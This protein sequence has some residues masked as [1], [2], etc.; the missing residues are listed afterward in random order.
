MSHRPL[1]TRPRLRHWLRQRAADR[2]RPPLRGE[3]PLQRGEARGPAGAEQQAP[4]SRASRRTRAR[5]TRG[6]ETGSARLPAPTLSR[7]ITFAGLSAHSTSS[8]QSGS[9]ADGLAGSGRLS[10]GQSGQP[11]GLSV[12]RTVGHSGGWAFG[13]SERVEQVHGRTA[14]AGGRAF[15]RTVG[16]GAGRSGGLSGGRVGGRTVGGAVGRTGGR[17]H[18]AVSAQSKARLVVRGEIWSRA[19]LQK[20]SHRVGFAF[21]RLGMALRQNC[22]DQAFCRAWEHNRCTSFE[23]L[24]GATSVGQ[25]GQL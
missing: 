11:G 10:V 9:R 6:D 18:P 3:P 19:F 12:G 14:C 21:S 16:R 23:L 13:R 20:C 5:A 8:G 17:S 15:G 1:H 25:F 22:G 2:R 4:R 7:R 24:P